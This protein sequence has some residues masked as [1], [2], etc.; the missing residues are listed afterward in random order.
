[1]RLVKVI[2]RDS[3]LQHES[4]WHTPAQIPNETHAVEEVGFVIHEDDDNITLAM[5]HVIATT[6]V[7]IYGPHTIWKPSIKNIVEIE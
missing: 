7:M 6:D 1:M 5:G 3:G 2:W 4:G